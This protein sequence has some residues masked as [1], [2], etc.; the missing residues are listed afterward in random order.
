[1][2]VTEALK[3]RISVRAFK[4][5]PIPEAL[6]RQI[7][8]VARFAPSGGNLQP[9][10][11]IAVAGAERDAVAALARANLPGDE[12][13]RLVYPANLWEPYRTRRYKLGEDMYALLGIPRENKGA[14]LMHLAEN[15]NFFGAPVGLFFVIEKAMGHGQW[16]HLGMFMQSVALAAIERGVQS[17]MQEAWARVRTPLATHFRLRDEEM[18]YCGM[19]LGYADTT[20]PVNAL[21]SDRADVDEIAEFRGF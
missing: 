21:R 2:K 12:G 14:R 18:I 4:P 3:T 17:C 1:M 13:E 6:V 8:D 11:V 7:I 19:A 15:F 16:A 10:R 5:D 9:W 20:K